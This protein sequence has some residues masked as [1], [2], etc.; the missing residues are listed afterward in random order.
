MKRH[1]PSRLPLAGIISAIL[2][3][4][5]VAAPVT[6][7]WACESGADGGW[8]CFQITEGGRVP[9]RMVAPEPTPTPTPEARVAEP[10][11]AP[12]PEVVS[13]TTPAA[14]SRRAAEPESRPEPTPTPVAAPAPKPE[15]EPVRYAAPRRSAEPVV[16]PKAV[17]P[18]AVEP[19][20]VERK[21]ERIAEP[22][23][24]P[25]RREAS[26][27]QATTAARAER[28]YT[29]AG[30][31]MAERYWEGEER[32]ALCDGGAAAEREIPAGRLDALRREAPMSAAADAADVDL[33]GTATL[34]GN[35]SLSRA[36]QQLAAQRVVYDQ[37]SGVAD[38]EGG[39]AY[40]QQ[41][42]AVEDASTAHIEL[43]GNRAA[44]TELAYRLPRQHARGE[45]ASAELEGAADHARLEKVSYTTCA[46]GNSDWELS[47]EEVTL[48]GPSNEGVARDAKLTFKG[49]PLLYAPWLS[50][51]LDDRRK[52]GVLPPKIGASDETGFDLAVPYYFNLAANYD[53]T[54]TPRIMSERGVQL[55]GQFRYLMPTY[56]G[57]I[58]AELVPDDDEYGDTR[59]LLT[60]EHY[61]KPYPNLDAEV[62][63]NYV[64][65]DDYL[66]DLGGDL[67]RSSATHLERH[68]G[69]TYYGGYWN[70]RGQLQDYQTVDPI[71]S[72][73]DRPYQRMPQVVFEGEW[74][75]QHGVRFGLDAEYV[76]FDR[77][78][79]VT[80]SRL[81]LHPRVSL[82]WGAPGYYVTPSLSYRHTGYDLDNVAAGN[83]DD[84]DRGLPMFSLDGGMYFERDTTIAGRALTQTLEPRLYYLYVEDEDQSMLPVFDSA[85]YDLSFAQLFR[86]N[87]FGGTD[88]VG[89]ANQLTL[90]LS[91][92]YLDNA[93]GR[94]LFRASAGQIFY[95]DDREV[96]L[97]GGVVDRDEES[98]FVAEIESRLWKDWLVRGNWQWDVDDGDTDKGVVQLRY[99][100]GKR[101]IANLSYRYR[102]DLL[103][104]TDLSLFW[105]ITPNWAAI[106]RWN[107]DLR[108]E[109]GLETLAG[110]EYQSCCWSWRLVGRNYVN[111]ANDEDNAG[112]YL[113][114][115]LKGLGRIGSGLESVLE[116]GILGYRSY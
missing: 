24:R 26:A 86:E 78:V 46:P 54:L 100:P 52:S 59:G 92:R 9:A 35:V 103:E 97:P 19:K 23:P 73:A 53:A 82:D 45:A 42:F 68:L 17:E 74:P 114:L 56:Y 2:A 94:E 10:A 70:L 43:E 7:Q 22:E 38:A 33:A 41:G 27:E 72:P 115:E 111:D 49:V 85:T 11:P 12:T 98:D 21:V 1:L 77:D 29:I 37:N 87:R 93:S 71:I 50:F 28:D 75:W 96:T 13:E 14:E 112:I 39:V 62:L 60:L 101:R 64:S 113:Q 3:G 65:D 51:P 57:Q 110:F 63:I 108:G 95:F 80:G 109:R 16:K 4:P 44:F 79:G 105:P 32:W 25:T 88:R 69:A 61:A 91:S 31:A 67:A 66:D 48:D 106:A 34:V 40:R 83:P 89:D 84:P 6:G 58:N 104:Q 90:A 5:T 18:K 15:P 116:R 99:N 76:N 107:Y 8:A 81:D 30:G 36:D 20:A 55:G 47:A 102:R